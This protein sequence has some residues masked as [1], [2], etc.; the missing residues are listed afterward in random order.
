[1][2]PSVA[3]AGLGEHAQVAG[4]HLAAL[5]IHW[6]RLAFVGYAHLIGRV[7]QKALTTAAPIVPAPPVTST[8]LT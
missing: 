8:R 5:R 1:V 4:V 2:Q 6:G 3:S 7:C